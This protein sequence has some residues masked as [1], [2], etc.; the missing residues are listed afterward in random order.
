MIDPNEAPIVRMI[1]DKYLNEGYGS[2]RIA[3]YL[4]ELGIRTRQG[5]NFVNCTIQHMLKN[6]SYTGVLKC[7][8]STTNIFPVLQIISPELFER[9]QEM[10]HQRSSKQ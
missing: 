10:L 2:Y 5:S 9:T 7:G 8:E 6:E 3:N 1:F 4:T